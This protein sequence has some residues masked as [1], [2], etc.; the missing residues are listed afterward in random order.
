LPA[1]AALFAALVLVPLLF[2]ANV[3]YWHGDP[4]WGPRYLYT[5]L[6][7][8]VLP[9][10]EILCRW[11]ATAASLRVA[12]VALSLVSLGVQ[13]E[14]IS[15]TEWRFWYRLEVMQQRHVDAA[16]WS[17]QPFHWGAT[18][19]HYYWNVRQS[20]LFIQ[21]DN[22]Y[23]VLRLDAGADR[24]LFT[25][26]PDPYVSNPADRYPINS[27]AFW[28]ADTKHPLFGDKTRWTL[29]LLLAGGAGLSLLGLWRA[30]ASERQ[31]ERRR[32]QLGVAAAG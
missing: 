25:G 8:L 31:S 12:F 17:G 21:L 2:Y 6:P 13:L 30:T 1:L 7:Y 23:Q 15:V 27:L 22:V 18:R 24:Y 29:A 16:A 3:L 26:R 10:G 19:Y 9:L 5:A 20:P 32:S 28:W 11:R 4:A 14:A